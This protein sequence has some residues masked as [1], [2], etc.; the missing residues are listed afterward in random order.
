MKDFYTE[1]ARPP[2][3]EQCE[4]CLLL[5]I[6]RTF[7]RKHLALEFNVY[8][9]MRATRSATGSWIWI[10]GAIEKT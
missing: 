2:L 6:V 9:Y 1:I 10:V 5:Y 3:D 7:D 4:G 8:V